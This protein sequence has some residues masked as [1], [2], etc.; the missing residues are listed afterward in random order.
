MFLQEHAYKQ[1]VVFHGVFAPV[2]Y[3]NFLLVDGGIRENV[4]WKLTKQAG[5]K[6]VVSIIFENDITNNAYENIIDVVH[7]SIDLLCHELSTY[8]LQGA[9]FLIK[10]HTDNMSLL[11]CS[12]LDY[13]YKVGYDKTKQLIKSNQF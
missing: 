4:P 9:D 12:K 6:K 5:A 3:G 7:G 8:E 1:V 2:P 13:L 10:I 11:D